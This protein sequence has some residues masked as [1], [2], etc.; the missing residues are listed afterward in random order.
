MIH[1]SLSVSARLNRIQQ[2]QN[3]DFGK[4]RG[5]SAAWDCRSS[6]L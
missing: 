2:K 1:A 5:L 3:P 6:L 4:R